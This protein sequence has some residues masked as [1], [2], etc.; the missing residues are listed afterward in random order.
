[1]Y[2]ALA[3]A[4]NLLG[5]YSGYISLGHAAFFG[6]GA[7]A[8]GD[9]LH[10]RRDRQRATGPSCVLPAVGIAVALAACPSRWIA[11]R[12]RA[13]TFAIVTITLLFIVQQLAFNLH[14]LTHGS[15]GIALPIPQLPRATYERPF[16]CAMLGV[17]RAL[18][19][20]RAGTC[21]TPS[22]GLMLARDPRRRGPGARARRRGHRRQGDG[23]RAQRRP[24]RDG[25]AASGPTTSASSTRSSRWTRW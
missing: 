15:Q 4:W 1:M 19:A 3:S 7:Y 20:R 21:A 8:I 22:S 12:M 23:V 10:A 13:A 24:D 2:A 17:L 18:G 6:V 16:Y 14:G 5:G 25:R 9:L 11:L